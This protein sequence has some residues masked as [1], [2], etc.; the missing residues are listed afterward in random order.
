MMIK[1]T[2]KEKLDVLNRSI[3]GYKDI[4]AKQE[5]AFI[6][7]ALP[8]IEILNFER[9]VA[10]AHL[11]NELDLFLNFTH[12]DPDIDLLSHYQTELEMILK[13]DLILKDRIREHKSRLK[14]HMRDT[15]NSSAVMRKYAESTGQTAIKTICFRG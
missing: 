9:R 8:D 2:L 7:R 5:S 3:Q 6:N 4:Q 1:D 11:K 14:Q 10:F 12:S 15:S 13:D